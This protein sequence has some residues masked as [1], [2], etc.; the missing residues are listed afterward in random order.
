MAAGEFSQRPCFPFNSSRVDLSLPDGG[1]GDSGAGGVLAPGDVMTEAGEASAAD[2]FPP[3]EGHTWEVDVGEAVLLEPVLSLPRRSWSQWRV[4]ITAAPTVKAMMV[5]SDRLWV[6]IL[7][8][9]S[10]VKLCFQQSMPAAACRLP[11]PACGCT[12][13]RRIQV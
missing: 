5:V 10:P 1:G 6:D 11:N 2:S 8:S 7:Q 9:S 13:L 12:F 4:A 3:G